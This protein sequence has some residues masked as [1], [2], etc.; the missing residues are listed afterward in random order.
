MASPEG[1]VRAVLER[2][3]R[4]GTL[5]ASIGAEA[6]GVDLALERDRAPRDPLDLT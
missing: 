3:E 2:G 1:E 6:G 4:L 5:L